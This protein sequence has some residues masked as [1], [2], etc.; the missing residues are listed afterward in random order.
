MS[1]NAASEALQSND[2]DL[3]VA[4][5]AVEM[6]MQFVDN[7]R[8]TEEEFEK[9]MLL[10]QKHVKIREYQFLLLVALGSD[11]FLTKSSDALGSVSA[12]DRVKN[13]LGVDFFLSVLDTL[14]SLLSPDLILSAHLC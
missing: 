2:V 14:L 11:R 9:Y 13:E 1:A 4:A 6:L 12:E 3:A 5:H 7:L 10:R 8:R